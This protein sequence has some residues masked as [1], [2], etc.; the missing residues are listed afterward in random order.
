LFHCPIEKVTHVTGLGLSHIDWHPFVE[1]IVEYQANPHLTYADSK[2]HH[3]Y[4]HCRPQ[5]AAEAMFGFHFMPEKFNNLPPHMIFLSPWSSFNEEEITQDT[6]WW[7][8][9]DNTEHGR[10]DLSYPSDGWAFFGPVSE[11]KGELEFRRTVALYDSIKEH[12]YDLSRG[13]IGVTVLK[14]GGDYRYLL[15]GGGYHR[16]MAMKAANYETIIASF[17][18]RSLVDVRDVDK[19]PNVTNGLWT[20][21]QALAYVDHLFEFCSID[22]A[23]EKGLSTYP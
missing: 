12:G 7:N 9:K 17:H 18:R 6:L 16:A 23:V 1:T 5:N 19:W 14:R 10:A 22:W 8:R 20:S 4:R 21:S 11:S 15:G 3:F 13:G 2:L